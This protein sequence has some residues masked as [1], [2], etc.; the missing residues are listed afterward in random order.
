[1]YFVDV[2]ALHCIDDTEAC[3]SK[4]QQSI[5]ARHHRTLQ[6]AWLTPGL[7]AHRYEPIVL[8]QTALLSQ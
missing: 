6:G 4:R 5:R 8:T 7:H 2:D 3:S 1:M